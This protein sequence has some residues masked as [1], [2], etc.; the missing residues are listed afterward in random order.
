LQNTLATSPIQAETSVQNWALR[1]AANLWTKQTS[2]LESTASQYGP[3]SLKEM[4]SVALMD[5]IDTKYVLSFHQ[6]V[7]TLQA[8]ES[9]YCILTI[10]GRRLMHY[11]TLY[12]DTPEFTLYTLHI[13]NRAERYKVRSREY[14]D[15]NISFLEVKQRTRKNR[16]VK[17]RIPTASQVLQL[18]MDNSQW[19][20]EVF[21]YGGACLEPKLANSF[22]RITLVSLE[23]S[24]RVT[25]DMDLTFSSDHRMRKLEGVCVAEVKMDAQNHT[26][27]FASYM[28]TCH[29]RPM[30]FSKYC[31]GVSMLYEQVKKNPLKRKMLQVSKI[32]E[33]IFCYE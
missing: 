13:D 21:P 14:V 30:G 3:I 2:A 16:T 7:N 20:Q 31:M 24:E 1:P 12:F 29:I 23:R 19:L 15:S 26:S 11:R 32:E 6:L 28:H 8:L 4:D 5:R 9:D 33:G 17:Q 10:H 27:P 25:L 18:N 22:T